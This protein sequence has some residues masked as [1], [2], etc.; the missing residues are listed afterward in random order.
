[1]RKHGVASPEEERKN[2]IAIADWI[3]SQ[4]NAPPYEFDSVWQK[5]RDLKTPH[6]FRQG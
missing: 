5:G 1:M 3:P 2:F 6:E 4:R